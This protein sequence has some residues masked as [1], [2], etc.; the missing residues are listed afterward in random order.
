MRNFILILLLIVVEI[1]N[2]YGRSNSIC[3]SKID[4]K[5]SNLYKYAEK[6]TNEGRNEEALT[7]FKN[8][9]KTDS[10]NVNYLWHTSIL[11]SQL[12]ISQPDEKSRMGWYKTAESLAIKAVSVDS[13]IAKTH[14]AYAIA[15]G[16]LSEHANTKIQIKYAKL[17]KTEAETAIRQ[18]P[19]LGTAYHILGKW[20]Y[21]VA[22]FNYLEL[23]MIK[24]LFGGIPGGTY[25]DAVHN[26]EMAVKFEP[27]R[28]LHYL[29]LAKSYMARN[30]KGD[31]ES[32]ISSLNKGIKIVSR[33]HEETVI[34]DEALAYLKKITKK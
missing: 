8:L 17:V 13:S 7:V 26:F 27:N 11:Y 29:E 25:N 12:G 21:I 33:N 6:L 14:L 31:K 34:H 9:L 1:P 5:E 15:I 32:A 3:V 16:R 10:N 19:K 28:C 20:H 18:D 23:S 30:E 24:L 4:E 22:G 2:S